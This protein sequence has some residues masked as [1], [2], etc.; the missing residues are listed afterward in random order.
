MLLEEDSYLKLP[1]H[2]R[3]IID[4]ILNLEEQLEAKY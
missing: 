3:Q 1:D 2:T 4:V